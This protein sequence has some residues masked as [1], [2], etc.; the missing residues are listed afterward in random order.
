MPG[1]IVLLTRCRI[2]VLRHRRLARSAK[3]IKSLIRAVMTLCT[4]LSV[5]NTLKS[6]KPQT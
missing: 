1:L 6:N 4:L 5:W 2:S 3:L